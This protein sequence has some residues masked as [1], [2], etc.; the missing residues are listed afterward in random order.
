MNK[1]H[2]G[3]QQGVQQVRNFLLSPNQGPSSAPDFLPA[4]KPLTTPAPLATPAH[5]ATPAP[6][7]TL[8]PP[9]TPATTPAPAPRPR[10]LF[11]P[12]TEFLLQDEEE[13]LEAAKKE[14][15]LYDE[16]HSLTMD[17]IDLENEADVRKVLKEKL[18]RYKTIMIKKDKII[19]ETLEVAKSM[20]TSIQAMKH[21]NAMMDEI[22][23]DYAE[24]AEN[25]RNLKETLAKENAKL[26]KARDTI[27]KE[28]E[29]T[30][31]LNGSLNKDVSDLKIQI[32]V[33]DGVIKALKETL[34]VEDEVRVVA[35]TRD[36]AEKSSHKCNACDKN[37]RQSQDLE[38][39][40]QDRHTE[41][42]C[43]YCEKMFRSEATLV[44]HHKVCTKNVGLANSMCNNCNQA[45]TEQ[46]LK[47]HMKS[48][49]D[50]DK[51]LDC[52][53]CG[54]IFESKRAV[55]IHR[56]D[57]HVYEPVRSRV[58]CKHWRKG[59]CLKGDS[60]GFSHVGHQQSSES[61]NTRKETTKVP[62]C[63]N[64][65]SCEWMA[66]GNCSY[67]HPRIGVQ[68]QWASRD[69]VSSGR[70][71][72]RSHWDSRS[73][74]DSRSH[75]DSR[76]PQDSWVRPDSNRG[77]AKHIRQSDRSTCKFDGRCERIPNC[78]HMHYKEDFPPFQGRRN[79]TMR[80]NPNQWRN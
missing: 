18:E 67:F 40:V 12:G 4:T 11:S 52:P 15:D 53:E 6:P 23:A 61:R 65:P 5:P 9:A 51:S 33:K 24:K 25:D 27:S 7:A 74:R 37:F 1:F 66:K 71:D 17:T 42:E 44:K 69:R 16:L 10:Q 64:G 56:D 30:R 34:A 80:R 57:R 73:H 49:K 36:D 46:G 3:V 39:H 55:K 22:Q 29:T 78:P 38:K 70:P 14:Q 20:K 62:E 43:V 26:E 48:C 79:P 54:E 31:N 45:F 72:S 21:D 60:C 59:H 50:N 58:V 19:T 28:L 76:S 41:S 75:Q 13:V 77:Q 47:R 2:A 8:A 35:S 32:Q 63:S 68:K